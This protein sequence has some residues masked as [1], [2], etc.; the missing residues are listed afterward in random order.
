MAEA[1]LRSEWDVILQLWNRVCSGPNGDCLQFGET[2]L[3]TRAAIDLQ[4]I[5]VIYVGDIPAVNRSISAPSM[6]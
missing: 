5:Q 2:Y 3:E 4:G 6:V 1:A